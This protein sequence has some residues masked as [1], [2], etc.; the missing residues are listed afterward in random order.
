M[1][2]MVTG[3]AGSGK[4]TFYR[5]AKKYYA[6]THANIFNICDFAFADNVKE[7]AY[8]LGWDGNKDAKGRKLLQDVGA[9]GRAYNKD[10]WVNYVLNDIK[11]ESRNITPVITDLRFAN[12][13]TVIRDKLK[14]PIYVV[15]IVGRQSDLGN[16]A[17]DVS[18]A[19][20]TEEELGTKF[21]TI[22]NSGTMEEF[23]ANVNNALMGM[24]L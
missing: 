7:T 19:G 2:I 9:I 1:I 12:E 24:G 16:N 13:Y 11:D 21:I 15:K 18:E 10:I 17:N 14:E 22:D 20:L 5:F 8:L 23:E 3:K 6:C 4:D